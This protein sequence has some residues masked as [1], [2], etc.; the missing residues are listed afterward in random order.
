MTYDVARQRVVLFG[1][2]N[3]SL[4]ADTWEWDGTTW[5]QRLPTTSPSPRVSSATYDVLR[6]RVV[7]F[8]GFGN[9]GPLSDTWEWD[10]SNWAQQ[11]PARNPGPREY[12]AMAYDVARQRIVLF[13]GSYYSDTW[14]F[15]PL[16]P[17][18][19]QPFGT[20]CAGSRGLP[21]LTSNA[22]YL[23]NPAFALDLLA[24]RPASPCV[25]GVSSGTQ[26]LPIGPCTLYLRD[27]ILPSL[28]VTNWAGFAEA[29]RVAIPIDIALR[30]VTLHAQALVVDPQAVLGLA[31]SAGLRLVLGD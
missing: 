17:A 4:L 13:G 10:G 20:A 28:A 15:G 26:S 2:G 30:G 21:V 23:G 22:P 16:I 11:A 25:F 12:H 7:L 31:F 24:A 5:T 18:I 14:L 1:R 19:A 29:P 27:P 8:G 9:L 3:N 6:Q